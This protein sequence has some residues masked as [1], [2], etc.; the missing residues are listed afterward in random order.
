MAMKPATMAEGE[1]SAS[2]RNRAWGTSD[3]GRCS[4]YRVVFVGASLLAKVVNDD[5]GILNECGA[6][7]FFASK[8]A[9]TK[10]K[11]WNQA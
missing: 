10:E 5:A 9:P 11:A 4:F 7:T 8:L 3:M 1:V 6:Y 2:G